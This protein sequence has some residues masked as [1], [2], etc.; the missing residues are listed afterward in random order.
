MINVGGRK[1]FPEEVERVLGKAPGVREVAILGVHDSLRGEVAAG[2][3]VGETGLRED[4]LLDFCRRRLAPHRVPRRL[5]V[6]SSL[7]RTVLGKLDTSHLRRLLASHARIRA[8]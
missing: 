7:P 6:L 8:G 5:L 4:R 3:V 1:V 2:A